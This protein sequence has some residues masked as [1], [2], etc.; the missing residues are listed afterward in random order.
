MD[1]IVN[2]A[3]KLHYMFAGQF[4]LPWSF[5]LLAEADDSWL[6]PT[7]KLLMQ[8]LL[9]SLVSRWFPGTPEDAKGLLKASIRSNDPVL[10]IEHA[11]MYQVRGEVPDGDF[12]IPIVNRKYSALGRM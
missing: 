3:A 9:I 7:R 11:T 12:T 8:S 4:L 2:Q 6:P 5:G 10:F 1:H